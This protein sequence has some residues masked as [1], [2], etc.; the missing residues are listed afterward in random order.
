MGRTLRAAL[1]LSLLSSVIV[2]PSL[3][4]APAWS[5]GSP[6]V[7][8]VVPLAGWAAFDDVQ[9]GAVSSVDVRDTGVGV[10]ADS[11]SYRVFEVDA[12]GDMRVLAGTGEGGEPEDGETATEASITA[13]QEAV[14]ATSSRTFISGLSGAIH[15][16]EQGEI[17]TL[18]P[19]GELA[20]DGADLTLAADEDTLYVGT[21]SGEIYEIDPQSPDS[22]TVIADL[23]M[24]VS[25]LD[26]GPN[27]DLYA[28]TG[29]MVVTVEDGVASYPLY[30]PAPE[31]VEY[32]IHDTAALDVAVA[33]DG[34]VYAVGGDGLLI[35]GSSG[36]SVTAYPTVTGDTVAYGLAGG[37]V[38]ADDSGNASLAR[39]DESA[40]V[41]LAAPG[42]VDVTVGDKEPGTVLSMHSD[43]SLDSVL[44][45][46]VTDTGALSPVSPHGTVMLR[47]SESTRLSWDEND[48]LF[49]QGE[50][51]AIVAGR[52]GYRFV[53][54]DGTLHRIDHMGGSEALAVGA[55]L[56]DGS[57]PPELLHLAGNEERTYFASRRDVY[58]L[59]GGMLAP[60]TSSALA[61]SNEEIV[62]LAA[63]PDSE[64]VYAAVD[65]GSAYTVVRV[66]PSGRASKLFDTGDVEGV[67]TPTGLVV[68]HGE[69]LFVTDEGSG[70]VLRHTGSGSPETIVGGGDTTP[71]TE[72]AGLESQLTAPAN[73]TVDN[74][75]TLFFT[76]GV[77]ILAVPA[78]HS[79]PAETG[80][81]V[82]GM[83]LALAITLGIAT[84]ILYRIHGA[85][86][87]AD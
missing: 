84:A 36:R 83:T 39:E 19:D 13:P 79:A 49:T 12:A 5:D 80:Y 55:S 30:P 23:D 68:G 62:A 77:E 82:G 87:A 4:A 86:P 10:I 45:M 74:V 69:T 18:I 60:F 66:P 1:G 9:L 70:R 53:L 64:T 11:D 35:I 6:A 22:D 15:L 37:V 14:S 40:P 67:F 54:S 17:E 21:T 57:V 2:A 61:G 46:T 26:V 56:D 51:A 78:A 81:P 16:V 25:G 63:A 3:V 52:D 28:A 43:P 8:T 42:H 20:D 71:T 24:T 27:G 7:P 47:E 72:A 73:P 32:E 41:T 48:V 85:L 31:D 34:T 58:V 44:A 33:P 50:D 76:D 75:G 65:T 29:F 59:E 38:I